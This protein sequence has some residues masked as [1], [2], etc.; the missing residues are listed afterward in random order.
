MGQSTLRSFEQLWRQRGWSVPERLPEVH[1]FKFGNGA[2]ETSHFAIQMPVVLA[3]K[4]GV[5]R[6]SIIRGDAPLLISRLALKRLGASLDFKRD[7]LQVFDTTVPL[8]TN[9]AGQYVVNLVGE[10]ESSDAASFTEVM[11][12]EPK[13]ES[14]EDDRSK[15]DEPDV[16]PMP[17]DQSPSMEHDPV[18]EPSRTGSCVGSRA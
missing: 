16:P 12:L 5:I 15:H 6:A 2:V 11:A 3:G 8:Q 4:R 18:P 17:A 14:D 10:Q 9:S 1:Q 7:C 13:P